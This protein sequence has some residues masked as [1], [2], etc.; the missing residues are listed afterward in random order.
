M[1]EWIAVMHEQFGITNKHVPSSSAERVFRHK[2]FIE[3]A[4]EYLEATTDEARLDALVDLVVF[5]LGAAEREGY[6]P[7]WDVAYRRVMEAN[8]NKTLGP[9]TKRGSYE[10]D[11]IKPEGWEPA[12]L[13][14]LFQRP[15]IVSSKG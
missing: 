4:T 1:L 6:L 9:N 2:A 10:L 7:L 8:L 13:S 12:D 5:A 14:D 11:L 15:K 3:E